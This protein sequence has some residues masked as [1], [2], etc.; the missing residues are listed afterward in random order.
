VL[1]GVVLLASGCGGA[2]SPRVAA[3]GTT[4]TLSSPG[5]GGA[6]GNGSPPASSGGTSGSEGTQSGNTAGRALY[7]LVRGSVRQMTKFAACVRSHG[8]PGFPDPNAQGQFSIS[9]VTA[10]GVDPRSPQ[11]GQ[12]VQACEQDLPNSGPPAPSPAAQA[13]ARRQALAFSACMRSHGVPNFPDP[14]AQGS[15]SV[16]VLGSDSPKYRTATASCA[17]YLGKSSKLGPGAAR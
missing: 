10:G 6:A 14:D 15:L 16:R 11:L 12:A 17:K 2:A 13:Q 9:A 7:A 4:T 3:I 1:A 8:E 5:R